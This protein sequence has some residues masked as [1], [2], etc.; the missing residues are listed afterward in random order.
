MREE[1]HM[2]VVPSGVA[3]GSGNGA[4]QLGSAD[5]ELIRALATLFIDVLKPFGEAMS[6]HIHGEVAGL[7]DDDQAREATRISCESNIREIF[8]MLRSGIPATAFVT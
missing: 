4:A 8:S 5:G 6:R 3:N 2:S 7:G 1:S